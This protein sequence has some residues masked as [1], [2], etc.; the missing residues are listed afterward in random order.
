MTQMSNKMNEVMKV[1]AVFA[2]I[3]TPLTFVAGVYG[4]NF[5]YIPELKWEWGYYYFWGLMA[6][7]SIGLGIFFKRKNWL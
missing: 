4:M 2:S 3:F 5:E 7:L 1:L 6:T